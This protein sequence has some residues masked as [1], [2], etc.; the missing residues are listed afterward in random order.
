MVIF[1]LLIGDR[2][3]M[4]FYPRTDT[5]VEFLTIFLMFYGLKLCERKEVKND[6]NNNSSLQS[7]GD[8]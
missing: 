3:F 4:F 6:I 2:I 8:E 7:I 5:Y 1:S